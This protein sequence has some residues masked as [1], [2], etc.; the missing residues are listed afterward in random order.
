MEYHVEA[1][2][3][4]NHSHSDHVVE[5]FK[6]TA[7]DLGIDLG[8]LKQN[9][10]NRTEFK[11]VLDSWY[12]KLYYVDAENEWMNGEIWFVNKNLLNVFLQNNMNIAVKWYLTDLVGVLHQHRVDWANF[13]SALRSK[14]CKVS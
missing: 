10:L 7:F 2:F 5:A 3:A 9:S 1:Y 6:E 11:Q 13:G 14:K 12:G 4:Y 8:K